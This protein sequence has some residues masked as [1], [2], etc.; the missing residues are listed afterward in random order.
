MPPATPTPVLRL[1]A[2]CLLSAALCCLWSCTN[3]RHLPYEQGTEGYYT[4]PAHQPM[5]FY[6]YDAPVPEAETYPIP[7]RQIDG[8]RV[9][10]IRFPS[11]EY[12]GQ[13]DNL[14]DARYFESTSRS[15]E[16]KPLLIV[17]PIWATHTFPSTN[18]ANG[19]ALHS[20][21]DAHVLWMQGDEPLFDWFALGDITE[22]SVFLEEIDR[23]VERFRAAAV[24]TRRLIDWAETRP[25]IDRNRIAIIGFSMS[26]MVA[27]N[28]AGNDSRVH[29]AV[30]VVGG[31]RP[32]DVMAECGVVVDYMR[33]HVKQNLGWS[34]EQFREF[35]HRR[36]IFG[37]PARWRG[38]YR[39]ENTLIIEASDDDC[40]PRASREALWHATGRP[41]RILFPYN[42]WQPFLAMTPVGG[43]VLTE[44]IFSFLDRKLFAGENP[45]QAN[46]HDGLLRRRTT[47]AALQGAPD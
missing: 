4:T 25:E 24:D 2:G 23:S 40:M 46:Y 34:Q 3:H 17:M 18:L 42:H 9:Y 5:G 26:A 31:A 6:D 39:P 19:Y 41:E 38:R 45:G 1:T 13:R 8:Y 22:E 37:D 7:V 33:S 21:G 14:V 47:R 29:T 43:N 44:D 30:Y 35:F 10:G 16:P 20:D 28:V 27:A 12:N 32:W 36:L 15:A 11:S